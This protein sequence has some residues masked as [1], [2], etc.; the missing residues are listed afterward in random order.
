M[1]IL[2]VWNV[3]VSITYL[4]WWSVLYRHD[5][6]VDPVGRSLPIH[7]PL[8]HFRLREKDPFLSFAIGMG[9]PSGPSCSVRHYQSL[10]WP[11]SPTV[12]IDSFNTPLDYLENHQWTSINFLFRYSFASSP[13]LKIAHFWK[14]KPKHSHQG[15]TGWSF[16]WWEV[17]QP[18][19][20]WP[21]HRGV[22]VLITEPNRLKFCM[23]IADVHWWWFVLWS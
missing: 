20:W 2:F 21:S 11:K 12:S 4:V 5:L 8:L 18:M 17:E 13:G 16:F 1:K 9:S 14:T 23:L 6:H 10:C 15:P 3:I 22:S 19:A 7:R